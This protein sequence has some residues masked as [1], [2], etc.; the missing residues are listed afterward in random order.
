MLNIMWNSEANL[1][2][3]N[4]MIMIII[5][6]NIDSRIIA[7]VSITTSFN[8]Y[9]AYSKCWL[10]IESQTLICPNYS[11]A[12]IRTRYGIPCEFWLWVKTY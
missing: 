2:K 7:G 6:I 3:H 11:Y 1:E 8:D 4:R 9:S 12:I 10:Q 5:K